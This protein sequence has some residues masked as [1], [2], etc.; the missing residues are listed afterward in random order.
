MNEVMEKFERLIKQLELATFG[1]EPHEG[2]VGLDSYT[3]EADEAW[4]A[5]NNNLPR[6]PEGAPRVRVFALRF[7]QPGRPGFSFLG[8]NIP[9]A[10]LKA[11]T[12]LLK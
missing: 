7:R 8:Y 10:V 6:P 12:A 9:E 11:Q 1:A 4:A 3:V 2:W 5:I